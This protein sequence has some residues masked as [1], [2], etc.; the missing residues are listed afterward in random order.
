M[1]LYGATADPMRSYDWLLQPADPWN[2]FGHAWKLYIEVDV[3]GFELRRLGYA[4]PDAWLDGVYDRE[5]ELT[6][7]LLG[8]LEEHNLLTPPE[9][10][11]LR[12]F[13]NQF[14]KPWQGEC[15]R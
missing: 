10:K 9:I 1:K 12:S 11:M 3:T 14:G 6:Q 13:W 4:I 15:E 8:G 5:L 7:Q 2:R